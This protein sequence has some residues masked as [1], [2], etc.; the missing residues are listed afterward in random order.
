MDTSKRGMLFGQLASRVEKIEEVLE[1]LKGV[2]PSTE[3]AAN[4][5]SDCTTG[6]PSTIC[7]QASK[8][9]FDAIFKCNITLPSAKEPKELT[10]KFN[11]EDVV[12]RGVPADKTAWFLLVGS[13][14]E[15]LASRCLEYKIGHE[16]LLT[17]KVD[18]LNKVK[19]TNID[20]KPELKVPKL[21]ISTKFRIE[22]FDD[23]VQ[24]VVIDMFD[25][26]F[27]ANGEPDIRS[28]DVH[29]FVV[30]T[31]TDCGSTFAWKLLR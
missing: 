26:K 12:P 5:M 28:M 31:A 11:S 2:F 22:G 16:V 7:D 3:T 17:S 19:P 15:N 1:E 8:V 27:V 4:T 25:I 21:T 30:D 23:T 14:L 24:T 6:M 20:R 13:F 29:D 9:N 10:Y 18:V